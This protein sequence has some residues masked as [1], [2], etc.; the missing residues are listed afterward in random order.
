MEILKPLQLGQL[1][2]AKVVL[3][4]GLVFS[5]LFSRNQCPILDPGEQLSAGT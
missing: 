2:V 3:R 1:L 5:L 4:F